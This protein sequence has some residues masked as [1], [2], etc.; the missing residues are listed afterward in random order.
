MHKSA[1]AQPNEFEAHDLSQLWL[2]KVMTWRL[3]DFFIAIGGGA[4]A[5]H[6]HTHTHTRY[7][8]KASSTKH[9]MKRNANMLLPITNLSFGNEKHQRRQTNAPSED[10]R[11]RQRTKRHHGNDSHH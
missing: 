11:R 4:H 6:T 5:T 8:Y 2:R 9:L 7:L 3:D 1:S 10:S